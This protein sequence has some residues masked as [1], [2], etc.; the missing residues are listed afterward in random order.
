[1]LLVCDVVSENG[2]KM[3]VTRMKKKVEVRRVD[4]SIYILV[5]NL[6]LLE[7]KFLLSVCVCVCSRNERERGR[8]SK[9]CVWFS[10]N[11]QDIQN[12]PLLCVCVC[13]FEHGEREE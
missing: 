1:M 4:I 7:R 8:E 6:F 5:S 10:T 13:K 11:L 9:G 2:S 12:N 3:V